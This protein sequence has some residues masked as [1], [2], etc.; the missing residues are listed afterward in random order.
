MMPEINF[1]TIH[2]LLDAMQQAREEERAILARMDRTRRELPQERQ[3]ELLAEDERQLRRL[4]EIYETGAQ[5]FGEYMGA[6][7]RAALTEA[8][9]AHLQRL[10]ILVK[11][12]N[13]RA[14]DLMRRFTRGELP[15]E[16]LLAAAARPGTPGDGT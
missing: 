11:N 8:E 14:L 5:A 6:L 10:L 4:E 3:A 9:L 15:L 1:A 2:H 12:R 13:A 7:S 16:A